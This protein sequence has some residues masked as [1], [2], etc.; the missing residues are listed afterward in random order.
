MA[1]SL[2]DTFYGCINVSSNNVEPKTNK[3]QE[4]KMGPKCLSDMMPYHIIIAKLFFL[5]TFLQMAFGPNNSIVN[6][7]KMLTSAMAHRRTYKVQFRH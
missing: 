7:I 2:T 3:Q 4:K 6:N 5:L 1:T